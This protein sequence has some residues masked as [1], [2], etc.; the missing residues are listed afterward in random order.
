MIVHDYNLKSQK[1]HEPDRNQKLFSRILEIIEVPSFSVFS[2]S[3]ITEDFY[4]E[5][6]LLN[7]FRY[8]RQQVSDPM[9]NFQP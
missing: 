8:L 1:K 6:H 3:V 4:V 7:D 5:V 9:S 2:T